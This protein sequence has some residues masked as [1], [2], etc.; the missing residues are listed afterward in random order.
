MGITGA[1]GEYEVK[2]GK[3]V[4]RVLYIVMGIVF[5][6]VAFC[7][8]FIGNRMNYNQGLKLTAL[9]PNYVLFLLALLGAAGICLLALWAKRIRLT[10][11]TNLIVNIVLAV[12]FLILF[13]INVRIAKE[14]AFRLPWDVGVVDVEARKL[15]EGIP[16]GYNVYFSMYSNN[17]PM[18]YFL[19]QLYV[20][21]RELGT[22]PY[23]YEFVWLEVNCALISLGGFFCCLTVKGLTKEIL[24]TVLAF[25]L[26]LALAGIS[27]WKI[28]PY[29]D[30]YGMAFPIMCIYFYL[31]YRDA[32]RIGEKYVFM[33]L[34]MI[35]GAAGGLLKP[36]GYIVVMAVLGVELISLL[37]ARG[38]GWKYFLAEVGLAAALLLARQAYV[39]HMM[40]DIGLD[41]NPEIEASWQN[42]FY[43]GLN[44][45][46]TGSYHPGDAGIIG[47]F[48]TDKNARNHAALERAFARM[49]ERGFFG[50]IYY[51]LRKMTMVFNDGTFGW[52]GEVWINEPYPEGLAGN[53]GLTVFLRDIFWPEGN[54]VGRYN[55][56]S[57]LAW[58]FCIFGI[59]G[60]CLCPEGQREKYAVTV[61]SFLGIFFYQMLFEARARYLLVFFPLLAALSVCG[62]WQYVRLAAKGLEGWRLA[63]QKIQTVLK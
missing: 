24:P 49:E 61:A 63:R 26:Y 21:A 57:Q 40:E 39:D 4:L 59:S 42:Y 17:V 48:Q 20:E 23:V 7:V 35:G 22:Y 53:D 13:F 1:E 5:L 3:Q 14:I 34:S 31:C 36:S 60:I 10:P 46:S 6:P 28:S 44:E 62:M 33:A 38:R 9:F 51:W 50:S 56:L 27:P 2:A 37:A 54:H 18:V 41:F 11:K 55:T 30:T 19:K 47:E 45:E 25:L 12:S 52:R 8:I 29:T 43:M 15:A 32:Q 58:I 16:L